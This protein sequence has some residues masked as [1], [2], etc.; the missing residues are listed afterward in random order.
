[1]SF[2]D[3]YTINETPTEREL[4]P[5]G[6][7]HGVITGVYNIG[8]MYNSFQNDWRPIVKVK[9]ELEALNKHGKRHVLYQE[10][11][12][13]MHA[14]S[15]LRKDV[16]S[17]EQ[18]DLSDAEAQG[19]SLKNLL[20]KQLIVQIVHK[21]KQNGVDMK[22]VIKNVLPSDKQITPQ[23]PLE[24]WSYTDRARDPQYHCKAAKWVWEAHMKSKD[25]L[26]PAT[27][28][29][30]P[31]RTQIA[32]EVAAAQQPQTQ[33]SA[34]AASTSTAGYEDVPF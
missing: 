17:I 3:D 18:R 28:Y 4:P 34:V 7:Q 27:P 15:N 11:T 24:I 31:Q 19:Y 29:I 21:L 25:Y 6:L 13:S 33:P 5:T 1:M 26:Q 9:I 8:R 2:N 22:Y 16:Q 12:A 23:V 10:Y 14:K 30:E 20:G 32:Q